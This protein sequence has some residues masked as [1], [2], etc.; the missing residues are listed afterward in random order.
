MPFLGQEWGDMWRVFSTGFTAS[1]ISKTAVAPL[2]RVKL[3]LQTQHCNYALNSGEVERYTGVT[4]CMRRLAS[5][6]G[7]FSLW[8]GNQAEVMRYAPVHAFNFLFRDMFSMATP[9]AENVSTGT[10][11]AL[12]FIEGALAGTATL[13]FVQPFDVMRTRVATDVGTGYTRQYR[14]VLDCMVKTLKM[15]GPMAYYSG[16][17]V[18]IPAVFV[19]RG[20]YLGG[21]TTA[22]DVVQP[23][24]F[25]LK[26]ALAQA[27]T[28][29]AGLAAYPLDTIRRRVMLQHGSRERLYMTGR[30][31]L[32][33]MMQDEGPRAFYAGAS[34]N[35]FRG[36]GGALVLL[37]YDHL[38]NASEVR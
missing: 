38:T 5:E 17:Y 35:I 16:F 27:V 20:V 33:R 10:R 32:R 28:A 26:F 1:A 14:G 34:A 25:A 11:A 23:E 29:A 8:R 37:L 13:V 9:E 4:N 2:D 3:I 21:W 31:C 6:Q 22:K 36:T 15:G 18:S 30:D 24:S 12:N 19:Y 7:V